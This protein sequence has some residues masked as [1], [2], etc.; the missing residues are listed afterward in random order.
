MVQVLLKTYWVI[1]VASVKTELF[2]ESFEEIESHVRVFSPFQ[3]CAP[4]QY[5]KSQEVIF[6]YGYPHSYSLYLFI[7]F[8]FFSAEVVISLMFEYKISITRCK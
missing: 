8:F 3:V 5:I 4:H 2:A 7:F 6:S 1:I